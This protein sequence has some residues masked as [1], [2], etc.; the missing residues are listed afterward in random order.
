MI[1]PI[2]LQQRTF[3]DRLSIF[4]VN[5]LFKNKS[6]SMTKTLVARDLK[7]IWHPCSQMKD[8]ETFPPMIIH[9]ASGSYIEL[10][11]GHRLIDAIS[12][13]WCKSLGH[14][15][16]RLIQALQKQLDHFEHVLLANTTHEIIVNLAEKLARLTK[17]LNKVCFASDGSCAVEMAMKMSVHARQIQGDAHRTRFIALKNSYHGETLGTM[18]VSNLNVY[19]NAYQSLLFDTLFLEPMPYVTGKTDPLWNDCTSHWLRMEKQLAPYVKEATAILVEPIVQGAGGMKIYSPDLL[20]KLR[21]WCDDNHIHLIADEIMTGIGRTGF[22]LACQHAEIEPDFLCLSKGLTS[23]CLPLSV[24]LTSQ[25]IYELFYDDY[26]KG[27]SFLHSH[28]HS[29]NALAASVALECLNVME[30]EKIYQQVHTMEPY[31]RTLMEEIAHDTGQLTNL[32]NIG[33]IVAADL[34]VP[35]MTRMGYAVYQEAVKLGALLRP[36]GNTIY[37]LPPLNTDFSTLKRLQQITAEA[38]FNVLG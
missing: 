17:R 33:A 16:P 27:K 12:S 36:L 10:S 38:I 28:T 8:Y 20:K 18:S 21:R 2:L 26:E 9:H 1:V 24:T 14:Q 37:W 7:H 23:G 11:N 30:E 19:Q 22:P 34:T 25:K 5:Y 6:T 31:L 15:H 13:W 4:S 29:G 32:R 35:S 3:D